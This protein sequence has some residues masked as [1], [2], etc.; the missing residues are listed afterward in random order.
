MQILGIEP[1]SPAWKANN[2]TFNIYLHILFSFF[3]IRNVAQ[4]VVYWVWDSNAA[5]SSHAI[6]IKNKAF[7]T[8]SVRVPDCDSESQGFKSP[9]TP[10]LL[11]FLFI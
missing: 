5:C 8:Q 1:R 3:S 11:K 4:L 10:K 6:P 2:L 9:Y 7:I